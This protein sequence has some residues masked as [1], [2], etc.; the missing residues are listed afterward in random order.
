[1]LQI[2]WLIFWF[3]LAVEFVFGFCIGTMFRVSRDV[4]KSSDAPTIIET[5]FNV[6]AVRKLDDDIEARP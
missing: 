2:H 1:M 3:I 6:E 5:E 4:P